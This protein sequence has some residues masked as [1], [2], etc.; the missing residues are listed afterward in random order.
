MTALAV[1][2]VNM[3]TTA[4]TGH[5]IVRDFALPFLWGLLGILSILLLLM[6]LVR[7]LD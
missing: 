6:W 7:R 4:F 5:G 2:T 1:N 3:I